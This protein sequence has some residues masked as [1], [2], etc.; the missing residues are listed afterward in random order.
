MIEDVVRICAGAAVWSKEEAE[1][2]GS[3]ACRKEY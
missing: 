3:Q 2:A 1:R